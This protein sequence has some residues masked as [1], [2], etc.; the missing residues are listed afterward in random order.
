[1]IRTSN[2]ILILALLLN[3]ISGK[4]AMNALSN[5]SL[6]EVE[7][8][9]SETSVQET[10]TDG[11]GIQSST[12][13]T[14]RHAKTDLQM[15]D[16]IRLELFRQCQDYRN[17]LSFIQKLDQISAGKRYLE[18]INSEQF[19]SLCSNFASASYRCKQK[20][21]SLNLQQID[22]SKKDILNIHQELFRQAALFHKL[23]YQYQKQ[24][25]HL[26][27][28]NQFLTQIKAGLNTI[29]AEYAEL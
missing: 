10:E 13:K 21:F 19:L 24:N 3:P 18:L 7:A 15:N 17:F 27:D 5:N 29:D 9:K 1:M 22:N 16:K 6:R 14:T 4:A 2:I 26:P 11:T 12:Q 23:V 28:L 25:K 8:G 20:L